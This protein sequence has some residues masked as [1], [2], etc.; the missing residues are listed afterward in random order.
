MRILGAFFSFFF[1]LFAAVQAL[2]FLEPKIHRADLSISVGPLMFC[3][4]LLWSALRDGRK[5][6]RLLAAW[7]GP[8]VGLAYVVALWSYC[9]F[10]NTESDRRSFPVVFWLVPIGWLYL[11]A[12]AVRERSAKDVGS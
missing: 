6:Q 1:L 8:C 5:R 12:L 11:V 10:P 4:L 7:F 9:Y 2:G 3:L